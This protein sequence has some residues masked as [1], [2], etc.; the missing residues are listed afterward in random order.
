VGEGFLVLTDSKKQMS[1][2][3]KDFLD[4]ARVDDRLFHF[5]TPD[6]QFSIRLKENAEEFCVWMSRLLY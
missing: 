4:V 1:L 5:R 2:E 6:Q 3:V